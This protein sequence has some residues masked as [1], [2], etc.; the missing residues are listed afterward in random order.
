[1]LALARAAGGDVEYRQGTADQTGLESSCA[2]LVVAAQALHW[3]DMQPTMREWRRILRPG[4]AAAALWNY[5]A[6]D[7]WQADYERLLHL[8]SDEYAEIRKATGTGDDNSKWV[9]QSPVCVDIR[10]HRIAS[11]QDLDWEGFHGRAWSSSYVEHGVR[12][13]AAFDAGLRRLF[14]GNQTDGA[15]EFRYTTYLL[16][17]R[18]AEGRA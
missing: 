17:W 13:R 12:D 5:R 16:L 10:E 1:M 6:S 7:G 15:V 14:D 9:K 4:G 11:S 3:F 18:F 8:H 2:D